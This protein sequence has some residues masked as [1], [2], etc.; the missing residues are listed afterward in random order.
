MTRSRAALRSIG[1]AQSRRA[2]TDT[3]DDRAWQKGA[4]CRAD[5]ELF[6]GGPA[7]PAA[8]GARTAAARAVC[9]RCPVRV[10][11]LEFALDATPQVEGVWAG[12]TV[13]ERR[14]LR[15]ARKAAS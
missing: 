9:N 5:P 6:F 10:A 1:A 12:T 4:A 14:A 11:C 2:V 15:R 8:A 7:T 3:G 13:P